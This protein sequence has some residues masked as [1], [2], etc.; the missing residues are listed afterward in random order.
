LFDTRVLWLL[1]TSLLDSAQ[2][3]ALVRVE[4][5]PD[6]ANILSQEIVPLEQGAKAQEYACVRLLRRTVL[7]TELAL[8]RIAVVDNGLLP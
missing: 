8:T 1:A 4:F 3:D 7:A 5:S 6:Y 2:P